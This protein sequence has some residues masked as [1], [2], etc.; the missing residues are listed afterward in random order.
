M[1]PAAGWAAGDAVL[2]AINR[3]EFPVV[4]WISGLVEAAAARQV[5]RSN[6]ALALRYFTLCG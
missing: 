6:C 4:D 3:I 5:S 2:A 1:Q